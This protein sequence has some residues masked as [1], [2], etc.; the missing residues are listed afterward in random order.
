MAIPF[1]FKLKL[2]YSSPSK[3]EFKG[4]VFVIILEL[5]TFIYECS[6]GM[7]KYLMVSNLCDTT[8]SARH[9]RHSFSSVMP[10]DNTSPSIYL[11]IKNPI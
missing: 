8:L 11:T 7:L 1:S 2:R 3:S 10:F 4:L 9:I 5:L 6:V